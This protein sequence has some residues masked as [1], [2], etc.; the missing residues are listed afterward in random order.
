[1]LGGVHDDETAGSGINNEVAGPGHG[2]GQA[3]SKPDRL[4]VRMKVG[5]GLLDPSAPNAVVDPG[6]LCFEWW[7]LQHQQIITAA[8][9]P[10]SL[11]ETVVISRNEINALQN[12]GNAQMVRL[13]KPERINPLHQIAA[14]PQHARAIS[15]Q[16]ASM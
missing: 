12:I 6:G 11:P 5:S 10:V 8:S 2:A 4:L 3:S 13:A 14:R 9:R 16:Q 1:M 7:P 15:R